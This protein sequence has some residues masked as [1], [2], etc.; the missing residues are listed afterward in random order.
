MLEKVS[1]HRLLDPDCGVDNKIAISAESRKVLMWS[2]W[3]LRA[4]PTNVKSIGEL[5]KS[6]FCWSLQHKQSEFF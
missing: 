6:G 4:V 5:S 2:L 3:N 1:S